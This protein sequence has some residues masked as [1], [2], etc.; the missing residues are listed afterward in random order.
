MREAVLLTTSELVASVRAVP[1]S[2]TD[3]VSRDALSALAS[4]LIRSAG[5]RWAGGPRGLLDG[6]GY[7]GRGGE[8][9]RSRP[10]YVCNKSLI[11]LSKC[12]ERLLR[13]VTVSECT[14]HPASIP[15]YSRPCYNLLAEPRPL[16]TIGLI[17]HVS[18]VWS[19]VTQVFHQDTCPITTP[20]LI[21]HAGS[22]AGGY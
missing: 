11:K 14:S 1:L 13:A 17:T 21:W 12:A 9:W 8:D 20:V 5:S 22:D 4:G 16:T 10:F 15:C 7:G 6:G 19:V 18:A 2:V 3:V